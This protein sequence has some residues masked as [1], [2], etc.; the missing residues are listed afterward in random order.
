MVMLCVRCL[1]V[2]RVGEAYDSQLRRS[3]VG[4][5]Y[6][7]YVHLECT[8]PVSARA[9]SATERESA[10]PPRRHRGPAGR[11]VSP[12]TEQFLYVLTL[13]GLLGAL[14]YGITTTR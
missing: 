1:L 8:V 9:T 7:A 14:A 6:T 5:L 12:R 11:A 4:A 2:V 10:T 13:A 3:T